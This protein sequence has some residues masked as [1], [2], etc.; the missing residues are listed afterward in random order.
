MSAPAGS[1]ANNSV[2]TDVGATITDADIVAGNNLGVFASNTDRITVSAGALAAI[3]GAPGGA[4]GLSVVNH[5]IAGTTTASISADSIVD[6]RAGGANSLSYNAGQLVT[7]FRPVSTANDP[8]DAQPSLAMGAR[9][10]HGTGVVAT[11]QQSVLANAVTAGV[12]F[13]PVSRR[14]RGR[15]IRNV[16]AGS[17]SATIDDSRV[18]TRL[19]GTDSTAVAIEAASHSYAATFI[20]V[21]SIGGVARP[22]PMPT[23]SW[24]A[25]PMPG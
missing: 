19:T 25:A 20:T 24:S 21:G 14:R 18:N 7:A 9:A 16:L 2:A 5:T 6:A 4:G 1:V 15:S 17:T 3:A 8:S 22:A 11:S 23:R 13:F 10:I 12:A